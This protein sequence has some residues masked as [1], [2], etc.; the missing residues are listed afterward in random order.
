MN[1]KLGGKIALVT[2][3]TRGIGLATAKLFHTEGARVIVTGRN[4]ATLENA[5]ASRCGSAPR[6]LAHPLQRHPLACSPRNPCESRRE[7]PLA[8]PAV[9]V[10]PSVAPSAV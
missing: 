9:D 1:K 8:L 6:H 7:H 2:G 10:Q 4:R 5:H 3:G